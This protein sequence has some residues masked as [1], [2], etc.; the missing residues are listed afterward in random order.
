M[1]ELKYIARRVLVSFLTCTVGGVCIIGGALLIING[2]TFYVMVGT[3]LL[4][5]GIFFLAF[6]RTFSKWLHENKY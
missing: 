2:T 1:S 3:L 6:A 5:V 4:L